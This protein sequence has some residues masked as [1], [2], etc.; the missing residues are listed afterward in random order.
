MS[1][2]CLSDLKENHRKSILTNHIEKGYFFVRKCPSKI[3]H[4]CIAGLDELLPYE[5]FEAAEFLELEG[6]GC[7]TPGGPENATIQL[8]GPSHLALQSKQVVLI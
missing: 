8:T 4:H 1:P 3:L 6:Q 7:V 5:V 2:E